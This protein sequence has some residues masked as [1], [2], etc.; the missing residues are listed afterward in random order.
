MRPIHIGFLVPPPPIILILISVVYFWI[1]FDKYFGLIVLV[2]LILYLT[3]TV[4][5]TEWRTE[6]R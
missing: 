1:Q 4:V 3:L 5:I 2:T 6:F